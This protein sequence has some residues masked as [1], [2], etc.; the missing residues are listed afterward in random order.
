MLP[1]EIYQQHDRSGQK[2]EFP[3]KVN[4]LLKQT[5]DRFAG[6][7]RSAPQKTGDKDQNDR[8]C[9]ENDDCSHGI[10]IGSVVDA[11]TKLGFAAGLLAR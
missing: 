3:G 4:E 5:E 9:D 1:P 8:D 7:P 6:I 10:M 2:C 11:P